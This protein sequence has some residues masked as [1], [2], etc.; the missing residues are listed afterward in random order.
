M[1]ENLATIPLMKKL[2]FSLKIILIFLIPTLTLIHFSFSFVQ[3]DYKKLNESSMYK[4]S[5]EI[6]GS[7][8]KLMHNLQI[9][10]GLSAGYIVAKDNSKYKKQLLKQYDKTDESYKDFIKYVNLKSDAKK[11]IL[12]RIGRNNRPLI[13][14][15]INQFSD[16]ESIRRD[17]LNMSINFDG[18]MSYYTDLNT[19]LLESIRLFVV[20][21][22]EQSEDG[23]SLAKLEMLK[24]YAGQERAYI[25]NGLLSNKKQ[26]LKVQKLIKQQTIQREEFILNASINSTLI[27]SNIID[28]DVEK[29]IVFCR[30]KFFNNK[31]SAKDA[32]NWFALATKRIDMLEEVSSKILKNYKETSRKIHQEA[33]DSLYLTALLWILSLISV[34]VLTYILRNLIKKE[35]FLVE[36]LRISSY[37]FDSH[38]AMT[39]TDVNGIILKVNDAFSRITGY[40]P[41][42]VI[43]KNPRVLKS[44]KHGNEFYKNMWQ[45]LHTEGKWSD[46]IYNKRKNGEI[47]LEHLSITAIKNE[48]GIT[49]HYIAQFLDISE[50]KQAQEEAQHQADHDFLTGLLNRKALL[51]RLNE[52]F[53]KARRHDFLHAFLF[54]DL[55]EFK[56]VND[57]FGHKAGDR[58]L[59]EVSKK[60]K[61]MLREEDILSRMSGDEFAI[62]ILNIDKSEQEAAKDIKNIAK[63][64]IHELNQPFVFDEHKINISASIGIKLFPD[65]EK[66]MQ[67]VVVH[68]DTAMY[69]AKHQG[70]NQF[71]FFDKTIELELKH[72]QFLEEELT[73]ANK[74]DEFVFFLQPKVDI[75]TN[76]I[77]GAEALLRWN[78]PQKGLLAPDLFLDVVQSIGM[79]HDIT[80]KALNQVCGFLES[81]KDVFNGIISIN[82]NSSELLDVDFEDDIVSTIKQ[83]DISASQIELEITENE[84]IQDFD[85]AIVK[86]KRLKEFGINFAIDDFGTGYSSITYLQKLPVDSLKIDKSFLQNLSDESNQEIIKMMLSM[87]KTFNICSVV[88]GIENQ[89]QLNFIK[90]N[91]ANLYQGFYSS[92]A[93]EE[94]VFLSLLN[95]R[96]TF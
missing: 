84:L 51:R 91:G 67:D 47:Y 11:M 17:V 71:V 57:N 86:I 36:E 54:I 53:I 14:H 88:E 89:T 18:E 73:H 10:R 62:I 45:Q 96:S 4:L 81:N 93:V 61:L 30:E 95:N 49:T 52:E 24:E 25:Y 80:M 70:K 6:T 76:D 41:S 85:T 68:A 65:N 32:T 12:E 35:E 3:T 28:K 31:L 20:L 26:K 38:E 90:E 19:N 16:I 94:K 64:I 78:H 2:P 21:V 60:L 63:K 50:L 48:K 15:V 5:A 42:E 27:Y 44:M 66:N 34:G 23:Y 7:L 82:I 74:N 77:V 87:A 8:S 79:V 83:F 1:S 37:T 39:I 22:K 69:Q 9:E 56:S 46:E 29:K 59:I 75:Q 13:K 33:L 40:M 58:L 92:Q 43:G 72:F 55:D